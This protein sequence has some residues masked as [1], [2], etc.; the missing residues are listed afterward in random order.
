[1]F[2]HLIIYVIHIMNHIYQP[3]MIVAYIL[4]RRKNLR[5]KN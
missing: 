5:V 4:K 2:I 3:K 1:M